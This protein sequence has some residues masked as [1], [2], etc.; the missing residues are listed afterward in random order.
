MLFEKIIYINLDRRTDRNKNMLE[1]LKKFNLLNITE[2]LSAVDG[3]TLDL[4][5]INPDIITAKGIKDAKESN[6]LYTVLTTGAIGCAMSHR[7]IYKKIIKD[8]INSCLILEDDITFSD[9]FHNQ[10]TILES[11]IDE[12]YDLFFL[13]YHDSSLAYNHMCKI[14]KICLFT[15]VYGLFGYIVTYKG[16]QKLLNMFPITSQ[17]D[18]EI[19]LQSDKIKTLGL[20]YDTTIIF[21]DKSSVHT[22]FGTDIQIRQPLELSQTLNN[23]NK[24]DNTVGDNI[25]KINKDQTILM[26]ILIII[27]L[28]LFIIILCRLFIKKN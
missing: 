6:K 11:I 5:N 28:A 12:D 22:K 8:K 4:N 21:S 19:S 16:A 9:K 1:L 14:N 27:L 15:H 18:S 20:S 13:G 10:L 7:A 23:N 17:I 26:I 2:R 24:D 25:N 3:K